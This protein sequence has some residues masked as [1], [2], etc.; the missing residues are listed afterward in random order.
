VPKIAPTKAGEEAF[1]EALLL[2]ES[3]TIAGSK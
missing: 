2:L 3:N 1:G